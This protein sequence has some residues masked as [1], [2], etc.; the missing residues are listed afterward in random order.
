MIKNRSIRRFSK[1]RN[2][3]ILG[4]PLSLFIIIIVTVLA[5]GILISWFSLVGDAPD[6]IDNISVNSGQADPSQITVTVLGGA[7]IYQPASAIVNLVITVWAGDSTVAG[8]TIS[9]TG[10]GTENVLPVKTAADGTA[11]FNNLAITLGEN[12]A[13]GAVKVKCE[14]KDF[15]THTGQILVVRG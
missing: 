10:S 15:M 2:A 8:A 6:A 5:L 7:D 14:K 12:R 13:T 4:M 9:L 1:D 11:T 3:D